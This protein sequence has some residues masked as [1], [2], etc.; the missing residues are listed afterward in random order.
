MSCSILY[1]YLGYSL[2]SKQYI[3]LSLMG[4]A[5]VIQLNLTIMDILFVSI[6]NL[7]LSYKLQCRNVEKYQTI[8]RMLFA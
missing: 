8:S 4:Y 6:C 5:R 2:F 1:I 3:K 7:K